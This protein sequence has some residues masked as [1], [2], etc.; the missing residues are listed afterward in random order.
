MLD[1]PDVPLSIGSGRKK[2]Q[3]LA[4]Q[5]EDTVF[6]VLLSYG[7]KCFRQLIFI[8]RHGLNPHYS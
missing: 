4:L 7:E 3:V 8:F 5:E 6:W 2:D 1:I